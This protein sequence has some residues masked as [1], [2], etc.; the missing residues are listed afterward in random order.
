VILGQHLARGA[1]R[2]GSLT[3]D[4]ENAGTFKISSK[5]MR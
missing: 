2:A 4:R 3:H 1:V 5:R